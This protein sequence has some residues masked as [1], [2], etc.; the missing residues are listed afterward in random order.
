MTEEENKA[1]ENFEKRLIIEK[2]TKNI[3]TPVYIKDIETIL[4]LMQ[5]LQKENE[6]LKSKNQ[7]LQK[8]LR[9]RVKEVKKLNKY[10]LYKIEFAN[11][12]KQIREKDKIIDLMAKSWKQD[13]T[14]TVEKIKQ[15]FKKQTKEV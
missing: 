3:G 5:K 9:N 6:K 11:L 2:Y 15:Y 7:D 14:R 8:K 10:S 1:I 4:N 13:D 12:N